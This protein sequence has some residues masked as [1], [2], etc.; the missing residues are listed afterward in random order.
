L[1]PQFHFRESS[2]RCFDFSL[3]LLQ[4]VYLLA[5]GGDFELIVHLTYR[6]LLLGFVKGED[7]L[8]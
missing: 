4:L 2:C 3:P 6:A 5:V 8:M 1:S 7:V